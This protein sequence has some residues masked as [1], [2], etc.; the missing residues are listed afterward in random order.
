MPAA[1]G[2]LA[3]GLAARARSGG[4]IINEHTLP[5]AALRAHVEAL[6][7]HFEMIHHDDLLS[8]LESPRTRPFC[9]MTF[10]D[11]KLSQ[12]EAADALERMGAPAVFYLITGSVGSSQPLWFDRVRAVR[13]LAPQ[14]GA[15]DGAAVKHL[16]MALLAERLERAE[17]KAGVACE[18]TPDT[19]Y[20]SWEQAAGLARRG[21]TIGAHTCTHPIL[22]REPFADAAREI[23][24][25]I[26]EVRNR[27]GVCATFAFPNGNYNAKL[28]RVALDAG[29]STLMTTEPM[30]VEPG[31]PAWRLP[32]L[33]LARHDDQGRAALKAA[34]AAVPGVIADGNG[35]GR[36]YRKVRA[37]ERKANRAGRLS[38]GTAASSLGGPPC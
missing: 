6:S 20:M 17:K 14:A 38:P 23:R 31:W 32:R 5:A 1:I 37:L 11:G 27:L 9:L 30:W 12:L 21:F 24:E 26:A 15:P 28:A 34:L 8:R 7:R 33:Q 36:V 25:S 10:D 19:A 2:R 18:P 16:P 4:L 22:T 35:T 3:L 29:V 13:R